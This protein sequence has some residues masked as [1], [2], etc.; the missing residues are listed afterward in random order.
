[1]IL[2]HFCA[3]KSVNS[4]LCNGLTI[5]GVLV[6]KKHGYE[7]HAGYMWLTLDSDP[8][9]QS[10][11][12]QSLI[13]YN[14]CAYRM[15]INIPNEA[16]ADNLMNRDQLEAAIPGAGKLYDGWKGS[17]N[18]MVYRGRIPPEWIIRTDKIV[19]DTN[20]KGAKWTR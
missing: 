14:R 4:I 17:E 3:K 2:Y 1:M 15:T 8:K 20:L 19:S 18:W 9:A 11:N 5:G 16:A 10:W 7:V 6:E 13:R 12:T